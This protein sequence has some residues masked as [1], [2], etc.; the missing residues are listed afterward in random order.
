MNKMRK[1]AK[2]KYDEA[3]KGLSEEEIA[4][5]NREDLKKEKIEQLA[6]EIHLERFPEEWDFM[7]DSIADADDRKRGINPMSEE[8]CTEV[9]KRR[10]ALGVAPLSCN[11]MRTSNETMEL[12]LAEAEE[13][14]NKGSL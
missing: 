9:K 2:R 8:Y 7:G 6:K 13:K 14:I 12:C 4:A 10:E 3:R 1:E 5:L 11:G